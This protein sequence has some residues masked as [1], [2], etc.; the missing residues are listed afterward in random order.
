MTYLCRFFTFTLLISFC[1]LANPSA[2]HASEINS[3]FENSTLASQKLNAAMQ[4]S[5]RLSAKS[6][7]IQKE[8]HALYIKLDEAYAR[9]D[10]AYLRHEQLNI[11]KARSN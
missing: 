9:Q 6:T 11:K 1:F 10:M 2:T 8:L 7:E 3:A 4:D 5:N